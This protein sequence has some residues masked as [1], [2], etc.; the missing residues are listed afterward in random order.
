MHVG[1]HVLKDCERGPR[2]LIFPRPSTD[3]RRPGPVLRIRLE[4]IRPGLLMFLG[5]G[6]NKVWR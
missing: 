3:N 5:A 1:M 4:D 2:I 6:M